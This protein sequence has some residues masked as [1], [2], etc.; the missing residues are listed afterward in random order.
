MPSPRW[1]RA[2]RWNSIAR[3]C[4]R[5]SATN[6]KTNPDCYEPGKCLISQLSSYAERSE[7]CL[8]WLPKADWDL[9][10]VGKWI[11]RS[12]QPS[13]FCKFRA[14]INGALMRLSLCVGWFVE[15]AGFSSFSPSI[16]GFARSGVS[17]KLACGSGFWL[18]Y[19]GLL[20]L[21]S[22]GLGGPTHQ[23]YQGNRQDE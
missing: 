14:M 11:L 23:R 18:Q 7:P 17:L 1:W 6:Q 19:S 5:E 13:K 12:D 21:V 9:Y 15:M 8:A 4:R 3:C 16:Q 10:T 20:G 22:L 2:T